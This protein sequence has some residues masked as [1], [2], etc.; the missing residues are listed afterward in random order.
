MVDYTSVSN[1]PSG[2][3]H[4]TSNPYPAQGFAPAP[5]YSPHNLVSNT[6]S[7]SYS[8]PPG[9]ESYLKVTGG[10]N[11]PLN[12]EWSLDDGVSWQTEK[13]GVDG[14]GLITLNEFPYAGES[15]LI[16]LRKDR[17]GARVRV[18][19]GVV[20]DTVTVEFAA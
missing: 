10:G 19:P 7:P 18:N 4:L 8:P 12:I 11:A 20:T 5:S 6:P 15:S 14:G 13:T 17:V 1:P 9:R 16:T 2:F 3:P